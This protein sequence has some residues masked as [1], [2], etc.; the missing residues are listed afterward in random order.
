MHPIC[1]LSSCSVLASVTTQVGGI[2]GGDVQRRQ[3]YQLIDQQPS[4]FQVQ[5]DKSS[6]AS[7][8]FLALMYIM[9]L[10]LLNLLVRAGITKA[11]QS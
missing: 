2:I 4:E 11:I 1:Q 3:R 5:M 10:I 7:R 6:Q 9:L 8:N